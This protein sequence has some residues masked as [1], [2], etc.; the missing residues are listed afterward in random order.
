MTTIREMVPIIMVVVFQTVVVDLI[1]TAKH[2]WVYMPIAIQT[3][4]N[5]RLK[6]TIEMVENLFNHGGRIL[7]E[8]LYT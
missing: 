2:I 7:H 8:L 1:A 3:I 4:R 5:L 6:L